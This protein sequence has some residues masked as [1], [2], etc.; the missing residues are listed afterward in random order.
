MV[1]V[2]VVDHLAEMG[3]WRLFRMQTCSNAKAMRRRARCLILRSAD[4][5]PPDIPIL[6]TGAR[7]HSKRTPVP[8]R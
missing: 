8:G 5:P 3:I 1:T 2:V 4:L 6:A 7:K